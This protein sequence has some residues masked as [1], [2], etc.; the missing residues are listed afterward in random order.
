MRRGINIEHYSC[1]VVSLDHSVDIKS[2]FVQADPRL[3]IRRHNSAL[4]VLTP[5]H[6]AAAFTMG[7]ARGSRR[8]CSKKESDHSIVGLL[9]P[10]SDSELPV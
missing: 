4:S 3:T 9:L 8:S 2:V 7:G 6:L 10:L 1:S 5:R